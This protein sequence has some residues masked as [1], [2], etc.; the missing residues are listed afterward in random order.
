MS[1]THARADEASVLDGEDGR[2]GRTWGDEMT[3]DRMTGT[4]R[5]VLAVGT[6]LA[7]VAVGAVP[8]S[9]APP[10]AHVKTFDEFRFVKGPG[11][12]LV[13][14]FGYTPATI[15]VPHGS[16]VRWSNPS[17][18]NEPHT[19]TVMNAAA[20]PQTIDEIFGC[21]APGALCD[22]VLT[23]HLPPDGPPDS[24]VNTG[25]RGLNRQGDSRLLLPPRR[26]GPATTVYAAVTAPAGST[27]HYICAFHPWMQAKVHV[28]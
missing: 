4:R 20:V 7:A 11:G 12:G 10:A 8:A 2:S 18:N 3:V 28:T 24:I 19:V 1:A 21:F 15:R 27:L 9:A 22:R 23:K 16:T 26:G 5:A 13:L 14:D 17:T 6:A 25:R